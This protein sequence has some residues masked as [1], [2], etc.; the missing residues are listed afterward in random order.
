MIVKELHQL[1]SRLFKMRRLEVEA[2]HVIIETYLLR[3]KQTDDSD[4][5]NAS[6]QPFVLL[7]RISVYFL[8]KAQ[9]S[10]LFYICLSFQKM[11]QV[12]QTEKSRAYQCQR[13]E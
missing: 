2:H 11:R 6:Y 13:S 1:L 3:G 12:D 5:K 7:K 4:H 9:H 8:N 10:S